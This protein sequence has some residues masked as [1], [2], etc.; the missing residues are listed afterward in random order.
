MGMTTMGFS[1][2]FTNVTLGNDHVRTQ[3]L[4]SFLALFSRR[5][6]WVPRRI[7][8]SNMVVVRGHQRH[9]T[10]VVCH[11]LACLFRMV[12]TRAAHAWSSLIY[13]WGIALASRIFLRC[14][15]VLDSVA[16]RTAVSQLASGLEHAVE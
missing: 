15:R 6:V 8:W 14:G 2:V 11:N 10:P 16:A 7:W 9:T 4:R 12:C 3:T 5:S 1:H 13:T